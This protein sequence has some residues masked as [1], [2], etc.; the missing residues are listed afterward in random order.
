MRVLHILDRL[1]SEKALTNNRTV[2]VQDYE[3]QSVSRRPRIFNYVSQLWDRRQ[4]IWED[5]R[6]K[7]STNHTDMLLGRAWNILGPLL[8][9]AMYGVVFGFLLNT[10]RGI[11]NFIGYLVIGVIFFGF[12]SKSMTGAGGLIQG[13]KNFIR[14]FS[15]PRASLVF[16]F[17]LR[18]FLQNIL[19][20]IVAVVF[21][22]A[23]QWK[24]GLSWTIVAVVPLFLLIHIFGCGVSFCVA[25]IT[26]FVPDFRSFF[27]VIVRAWFYSSGVFFSLDRLTTDASIQEILMLNPAFQFLDAIRNGVLYGQYP[28]VAQWVYLLCWSIGMFIIG[29]VFF[30]RAEERYINV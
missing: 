30:W 8:D 12:I 7:T 15:F 18:S 6:G 16:S 2:F 20:A 27:K 4:Y 25:R 9:A 19:P 17:N 24:T 11:E 13:N 28:G 21:G 26:A 14:S 3:L 5:A 23:L 22:L 1:S 10:S 29:L